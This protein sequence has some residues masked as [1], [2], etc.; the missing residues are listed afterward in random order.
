MESSFTFL[1]ETN[2]FHGTTYNSSR[3]IH[4]GRGGKYVKG[5]GRNIWYQK[6]KTEA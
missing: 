6:G 3:M 1:S 4:L 5:E 2:L